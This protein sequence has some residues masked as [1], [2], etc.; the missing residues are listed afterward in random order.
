[1]ENK[2]YDSMS[3]IEL[4]ANDFITLMFERTDENG[5]LYIPGWHYDRISGDEKN[6]DE[7]DSYRCKVDWNLYKFENF[8]KEFEG[9]NNALKEIANFREEIDDNIDNAKKFLSKEVFTIWD[10][11][12]RP[13]D[14]GDIDMEKINDIEDRMET[15]A[16][17]KRIAKDIANGNTIEKFEKEVLS[18]YLDVKVSNEEI[19]YRNEYI[20]RVFKDSEKRVGNNICAYDVVIRAMRLCRLYNLN[21][22]KLVINYEAR[23]LA[24]AMVLHN[25]GSKRELVDTSIRLRLERIENMED[26]ELDE[27]FRPQKSN[28]RKSLAPLFIFEVINKYSNPDKHLRHQEILDLLKKY[29]YEISLERKALGRIIHNLTDSQYGIYSDKSGV[30]MDK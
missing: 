19:A 18:E 1:M 13:F 24:A 30:W 12:I 17:V 3:D 4:T 6:T 22:P 5:I 14:I 23:Q 29:P 10:T 21:A 7:D 25:F 16:W 26:E 27:L 8:Q 15:I 2:I 28:T 9:L 11:Y 20:N